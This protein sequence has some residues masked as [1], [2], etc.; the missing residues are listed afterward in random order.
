MREERR[1]QLNVRNGVIDWSN[2]TEQSDVLQGRHRGGWNEPDSPRVG[3]VSREPEH[4]VLERFGEA[5]VTLRTRQWS[6]ITLDC[7]THLD[8]PAGRQ[9]FYDVVILELVNLQASRSDNLYGWLQVVFAYAA[10]KPFVYCSV[11]FP[12]RACSSWR[13]NM[14]SSWSGAL[15]TG[16]PRRCSSA[17]GPGDSCG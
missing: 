4:Q 1:G 13:A 9:T 12:A 11:T 16:S 2:D 6:A 3:S 7:P 14:T 5:Q 17:A 15:Y 10:G 8:A